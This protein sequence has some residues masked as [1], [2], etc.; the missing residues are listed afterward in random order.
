ME[1]VVYL[2]VTV[3]VVRINNCVTKTNFT[4][5]VTLFLM[6]NFTQ[7]ALT[8]SKSKM[9]TTEQ[10]MRS[11]QSWRRYRVFIANLELI[12][13]T[14]FIFPLFN[15][16]QVNDNWTMS[17][18]YITLNTVFPACF[19]VS[20]LQFIS[21]RKTQVLTGS[22]FTLRSFAELLLWILKNM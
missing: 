6:S 7:S 1:L 14:V 11:V 3:T 21:H 12:S 17:S 10:C 19:F 13:R 22:K 16:E 8:C 4:D 5:I 15:F 20:A 2:K 9:E 18:R